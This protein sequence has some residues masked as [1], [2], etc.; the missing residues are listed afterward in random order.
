MKRIFIATIIAVQAHVNNFVFILRT[1]NIDIEPSSTEGELA[2]DQ[3][4][5]LHKRRA[6]LIRFQFMRQS[7]RV[8][9][10]MEFGAKIIRCAALR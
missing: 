6:T 9:V 8:N 5:E 10:L 4:D 7:K 2:F 3:F 1:D